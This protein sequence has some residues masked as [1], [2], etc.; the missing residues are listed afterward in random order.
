MADFALVRKL[1]VQSLLNENVRV[2][3]IFTN[4]RMN[5]SVAADQTPQSDKLKVILTEEAVDTPL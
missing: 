1:V 3:E 5:H 4:I 2:H